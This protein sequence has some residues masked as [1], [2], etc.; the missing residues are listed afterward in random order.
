MNT[1]NLFPPTTDKVI[2]KTDPK[3]NAEIR[4]HT[5]RN[6]NIFKNCNETDI[7]ERI[8]RL[9]QEWDMERV[10]Q[11][12]AG[13]LIFL[14]SYMGIRISR[15]WFLVTGAVSVFM[16]WHALLG[17][18][19]SLNL[20]RKWGVRTENEILSEIIALKII[21]GD[22]EQDGTTAADYLNMAEK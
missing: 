14:S 9:N 21:R 16:L 22:F 17:W 19:P 13:V 2:R 4:N 10:V 6:L 5:I 12:K 11:V 15:I 20:L 7:T 1:M 8:K 18:C 3:I